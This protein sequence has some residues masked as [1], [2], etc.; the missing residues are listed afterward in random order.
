M[1]KLLSLKAM[2]DGVAKAI[3]VDKGEGL[4]ELETAFMRTDIKANHTATATRNHVIDLFEKQG[5]VRDDLEKG[6]GEPSDFFLDVVAM[7]FEAMSGAYSDKGAPAAFI[8]AN[9]KGYNVKEMLETNV[10]LLPGWMTAAGGSGSGEL[11]V[12]QFFQINQH[13]YIR[14][15]KLTWDSRLKALEALTATPNERTASKVELILKD[16]KKVINRLRK[17]E[18]TDKFSITEAVSMTREVYTYMGGKEES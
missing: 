4:T 17:L 7:S 1:S 10:K 3:A 5:R 8:K 11:S 12:R 14:A 9:P 15:L 13:G 2:V 6:A 18:D 16:V